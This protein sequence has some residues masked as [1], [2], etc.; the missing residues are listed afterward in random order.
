M[1]RRRA[2][3]LLILLSLIALP[4]VAT[5]FALRRSG[6]GTPIRY[7]TNAAFRYAPLPEQRVER[8]GAAVTI[9]AHGLRGTEPWSTQSDLHVLFV[10]DSVTWGG[11]HID[12]AAVFSSLVC[13]ELEAQLGQR[14]VCGNAGVNN[15][16]TDNMRA[17]LRHDRDVVRRADVVVVTIVADDTRRGLTDLRSRDYYSSIPPGPLPAI[18]EAL[19]FL[20]YQ[21]SWHI[22][23]HDLRYDDAYD[24]DVGL[25][26]LD[27]LLDELAALGD[28]GKTTLLVYSPTLHDLEQPPPSLGRAVRERIAQSPVPSLDLVDAVR[29][30]DRSQDVRASDLYDDGLHLTAVGH[31]LYG[32]WIAA[33]LV[34]ALAQARSFAR[35]ANVLAA[36]CVR[37]GMAPGAAPAAAGF[38]GRV[39]YPHRRA[40][41]DPATPRAHQREA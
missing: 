33:A 4:V 24:I 32:R 18:G 41:Q 37:A 10:G 3:F 7:G 36:P 5:E 2:V 39:P 6:L 15:Y 26:S 14:V 20:L 38:T 40:A 11:T 16:G 27:L 1:T 25:E 34:D 13:D 19:G 22:R 31:R 21:A 8:W 29:H 17:R 12:D 30:L 28:A 35:K 23:H 9:D